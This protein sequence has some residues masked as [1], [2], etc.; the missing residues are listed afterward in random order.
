MT[1]MTRTDGY[2]TKKVSESEVTAFRE[3]INKCPI[4]LTDGD[5]IIL[6]E[7]HLNKKKQLEARLQKE[8]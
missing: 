3:E 6:C 8:I 5:F 4:C 1:P 7:E 2:P